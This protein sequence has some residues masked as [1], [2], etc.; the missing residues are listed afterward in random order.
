MKL[1]LAEKW[2]CLAIFWL[3]YWNSSPVMEFYK[4]AGCCSLK[5]WSC[6]TFSSKYHPINMSLKQT[7]FVQTKK[8]NFVISADWLTFK[9][10]KDI[11]RSWS[12]ASSKLRR[13]F[14]VWPHFCTDWCFVTF[15][16]V[17]GGCGE[18][19]VADNISLVTFDQTL[20]ALL[21]HRF[22]FSNVMIVLL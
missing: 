21:L 18:S 7:M 1:Y 8:A 17:C 14:G 5:L 19:R 4:V 6:L 20:H 22:L 9:Q 10:A 3:Q 16:S 2:Q 13:F 11:N 12:L 15:S